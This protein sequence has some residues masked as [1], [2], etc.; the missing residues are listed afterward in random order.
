MRAAQFQQWFTMLLL[1]RLSSAKEKLHNDCAA[2]GLGYSNNHKSSCRPDCKD[3]AA[4]MPAP[5][6]KVLQK[7]HSTRKFQSP[8]IQHT[9]QSADTNTHDMPCTTNTMPPAPSLA[10]HKS[11]RCS[12]LLQAPGTKCRHQGSLSCSSCLKTHGSTSTSQFL[13]SESEQVN[14]CVVCSCYSTAPG[15]ASKGSDLL[16]MSCTTTARPAASPFPL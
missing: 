10:T 3:C 8:H 1:M 16:R 5:D 4:C 13:Q 7:E 6:F 11:P 14:A 9:T 2:E 12:G 15:A